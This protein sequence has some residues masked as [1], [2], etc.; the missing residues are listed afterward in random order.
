MAALIVLPTFLRE[1]AR[2]NA[3]EVDLSH[4]ILAGDTSPKTAQSDEVPF[5][6]FMQRSL[7]AGHAKIAV[8]DF[9]DAS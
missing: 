8:E 2:S 7:P 9:C 4:R 6:D 1:H 3:S 5:A